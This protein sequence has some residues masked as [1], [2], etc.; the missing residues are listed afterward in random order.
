MQKI[1]SVLKKT[2]NIIWENKT[3]LEC[4]ADSYG[5]ETHEFIEKNDCYYLEPVKEYFSILSTIKDNNKIFNMGLSDIS[6]DDV[7]FAKT[8]HYGNGSINHSNDHIEELKKYNTQFENIKIKTITYIDFLIM[9][10]KYVDVLVLDI[11]GHET[12]VLKTFLNVD[13]KIK[14]KI[15]VIECGYD[16]KDRL[17]LLK[18]IGYNLDFYYYNNAYLSLNNEQI[19]KNIE[20]INIIKKEWPSWSWNDKV[21]YN[22]QN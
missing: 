14:P 18:N 19:E 20:N 15:I 12:N 16:W 8:S 7:N 10:D 13:N 22:Q 11:E 1:S 3:F 21:I 6:S 4:G 2:Y 17:K 5:E 9:I